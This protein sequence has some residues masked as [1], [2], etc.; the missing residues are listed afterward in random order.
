MS[1]GG[2]Q[3]KTSNK[4]PV[5][6]HCGDSVQWTVDLLEVPNPKGFLEEV[7]FRA[8]PKRVWGTRKSTQGRKVL[9]D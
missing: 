5:T 6:M 2:I 9:L 8:S 3:G 4:S 1:Y 7:E